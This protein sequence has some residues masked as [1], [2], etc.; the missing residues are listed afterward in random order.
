[1]SF[2]YVPDIVAEDA[3]TEA[4]KKNQFDYILHTASP[5]NFAVTDLQ[6]ELIDPAVQGYVTSKL[7]ARQL[8]F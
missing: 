2:E 3:F 4:F 1:M 7:E 8:K 5:V 6:K